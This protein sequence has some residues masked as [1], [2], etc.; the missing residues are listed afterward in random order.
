MGPHGDPAGIGAQLTPLWHPSPNHGPRR[1]GR[2]PRLIVLHY[3]EMPSAQAALERLCD[4][5]AEV[6]AHYLIGRDG[7]LWQLVDENRRAWHAGAGTWR[8]L[9]DVNSRSI[10]IEIDNDGRSPFSHR[11]MVCVERLLADIR[12]RWSIPVEGVIAHSDMAP[13]RKV[14]PGARFDWRRLGVVG[15]A[16]WPHAPGDARVPLAQSLDRI[17]YPP[18][19]PTLRLAAYRLRFNPGA[20]GPEGP[21]D[22]ALADAVAQMSEEYEISQK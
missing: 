15:Q 4:P 13:G 9:E 22:R 17:G 21:Q 1:D 16:L 18:V 10:G 7:T 3:T 12:D 19:D 14:D 2:L 5:V 8:G 6:S 11:A 20:L